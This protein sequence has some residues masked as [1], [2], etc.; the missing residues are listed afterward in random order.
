VSLPSIKEIYQEFPLPVRRRISSF[1]K[2]GARLAAKMQLKP[3]RIDACLLGGDDGISATSLARLSGNVRRASSSISE[4]PHVKLLRQYDSIGERIWEQGVFEETEYYRNAALIIEM[5]GI[6]HGAVTPG[7]IQQV[8]RHFVNSYRGVSE[9]FPFPAAQDDEN[10][11]R[12][13]IL[14]RRVKESPCYEVVDGRHRL[15][16]AYMKGLREVPGHIKPPSTRTPLQ[17]LL[18]DV[19]WLNGPK[20]EL[21]QPI[22][23]P[24][25]ANWVLVRRC[26]DRLAMMTEFL[27]A[28]G[29]MPP[30]SGSYLDVASYFGWFV[31]EMAKEGFQAEGVE[32]DPIAISV[33]NAMYGLRPEQVHRCDCVPFL[34]T[35]QEKYDVISCF[36]LLHHYFL[37]RFSVTAEELLHLL[38]SATRRVLFFEMGQTD[39]RFYAEGQ[40]AGWNPDQIQRW[41]EANTTFTRIVRIGM[42]EDDVPPYKG[43]YGRTVFACVRSSGEEKVETQGSYEPQKQSSVPGVQ[44]NVPMAGTSAA[45]RKVLV[46]DA[47]SAAGLETV[48]SLGRDG[49]IVDALSL[50]PEQSR[51][52]SRFIRRQIELSASE[53]GGVRQLINLF[54][55]ENYDL[56]VPS[57]EVAIRALLSPEIPE[58]LY[59]RAVLASRASVQTALNK[60]AVW[61]LARRVGVLAPAS[62]IVSS[63]SPPPEAFPVVLKPVFSK[64]ITGG[65]VR[66]FSV[67]V[68]RNLAQW[69][70][71]LEST[72]SGLPVQQQ[73]YMAGRGVGVELLF[74][75]G[76][77]RWAFVHER[78]HEFPLTGGGSSYRVSLELNDSLVQSATAL[79][80]ALQWHGVAMVEFKVTPSGEAYLMEINPR[81]WGS[82][83][84][85]IDCG[86]NF[87]VGLLRLATG[88]PISPQPKYR[89]GYFTRDI[90]RDF[91]WFK[92]NLTADHSDPLLHTRP[93]IS[94]ALEWLRPLVGKESWDF[95]CWSDLGVALGEVETIVT[96]QW[97]KFMN[98]VIRRSRR[99]RLRYIQQ[100]LMIQ[101]LR[102]RQIDKVLILC[103]GNI[104]RSPF[105]A[106][107]ASKRF[108]KVP[109]SSAGLDA[110]PDRQSPDFVV[111][112]GSGY[113]IDLVEHRS[114]SVD[115]KMIDEAQLILVMDILNYELLTA[116]FPG[117]LERTLFLGMLLPV[118]QLEIP[119][120]SDDPDSMQEVSSKI[121]C[122]VEHLADFLR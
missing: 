24:E 81:L 66:E 2:H 3:I 119:D 50:R 80:S 49:C 5:S 34:R 6:Y 19:L 120:P 1:K 47:D 16:I 32:R 38:D 65:V 18:I 20:R 109:F 43:C 118:P 21:Y 100:P 75:H 45:R 33:G 14:V 27:R 108:P 41:L 98:A 86:V 30:A 83:A 8:A 117:A 93:I 31:A 116:S 25:V 113:G 52:R 78:V 101:K 114:K 40:L 63:S 53:D 122:A 44:R 76:T 79:L 73:R 13:F 82:L 26:S 88:Q 105:A 69:R 121:N 22:D 11:E 64:E 68:A 96:E 29:M 103:Y 71:A 115:A 48:Q 97:S 39:E 51:H 61:E 99:L 84:L 92:A 56:I 106:A 112:T 74:E 4:W 37:N 70:T 91:L 62:E 46:L 59:Q 104:C 10:S 102:G 72:Y 60:Q 87:P 95:F 110:K 55:A 23:S 57:T 94:S 7:E 85:A 12:Q 77:P 58:E 90:R 28:E 54:S 89:T 67:T 36:S 15:A 17:E 9:I 42:D 35:L 107:L 111:S